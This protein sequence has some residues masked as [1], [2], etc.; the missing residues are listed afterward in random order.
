MASINKVTLMGNLTRD[1]ELRFAPS[2]SAVANFSIA[3][4]YRNQDSGE[5]H[6]EF[7]DCE[8]WGGWGENLCKTAKKGSCVLVV[9]RL[10]NATGRDQ[11]S[12][13]KRSRIKVRAQSA[14]HVQPQYAN[15]GQG[16][17]SEVPEPPDPVEAE[18]G[19]PF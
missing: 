10:R 1:P 18:P 15:T 5:E 2:G 7:F 6:A 14:F 16:V 8:C 13:D 4:N 3:V 19:V 12:G 11:E 9:G 17:E